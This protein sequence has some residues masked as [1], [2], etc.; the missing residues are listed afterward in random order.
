VHPTKNS[1]IQER[2]RR[3]IIN[4]NGHGQSINIAQLFALL[5]SAHL[6]KNPRINSSHR[7]FDY[8]EKVGTLG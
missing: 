3:Y 6:E 8:L 7:D 1:Y 4:F 5:H 2:M